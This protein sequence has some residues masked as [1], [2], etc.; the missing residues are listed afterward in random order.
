MYEKK[1]SN[2]TIILSGSSREPFAER[3][4]HQSALP[5]LVMP[6]VYDL[7]ADHVALAALRE[8]TGPICFVSDYW[9]RA[10]Y[11]MLWRHGI[12]GRRAD[13]PAT[14]TRGRRIHCV[15]VRGLTQDQAAARVLAVTGPA[16]GRGS[17]RSIV[18]D[19]EKGWHP[20]ID[21]D[22]CTSCHAC[23]EFC[24]LG[25]YEATK[26]G[27][28]QVAHRDR[29]KS[30]CRACGW[31]CPAGAIMFPRY[32]GGGAVAGDDAGM[33]EFLAGEALK[34]AVSKSIGQWVPSKSQAA[35]PHKLHEALNERENLQ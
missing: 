27:L 16:A 10:A 15:C 17:V 35:D 22:R 8:I 18:D 4:I 14:Q 12:K 21:H 6:D 25:V 24:L 28:V 20:V 34:K 30:G 29:C 2:W 32:P 26:E 31:T 3:L 33:P 19:L 13:L 9:P 5:V 1:S 23:A 7:S 11:W